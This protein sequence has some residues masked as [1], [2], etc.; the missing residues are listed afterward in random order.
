MSHQNIID[1][2]GDQAEYLLNHESKTISKTL[3][4]SP[5]PNFIDEVF[6]QS[7][8]TPQ[9]LRSLSSMYNHGRLS[10]SLIHI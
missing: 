4:H 10:L 5:S 9:V 7:N 2:L 1:Q 8:R 3:L 6:V